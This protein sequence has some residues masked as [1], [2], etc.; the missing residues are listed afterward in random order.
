MVT[1]LH[2]RATAS[3]VKAANTDFFTDYTPLSKI[4]KAEN[5]II[6]IAVSVTCRLRVTLDG[7]NF[8]DLNNGVDLTAG[9]VYAFDTFAES[10]DTYNLQTNTVGGTTITFCRIISDLDA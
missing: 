8:D 7:T 5:L 3:G 6:F 10:T 1:L 4:G 9:R 2:V